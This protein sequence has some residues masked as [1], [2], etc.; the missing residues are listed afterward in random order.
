MTIP[1]AGAE[2]TDRSQHSICL[3][4]WIE[5]TTICGGLSLLTYNLHKA[6]APVNGF[7]NVS[8][9]FYA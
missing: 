1:A 7:R 8:T 2:G 4:D 9:A 3:A 5:V 6:F